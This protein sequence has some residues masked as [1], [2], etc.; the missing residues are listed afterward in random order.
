VDDANAGLSHLLVLAAIGGFACLTR[1]AG[2]PLVL[3]GAVHAFAFRGW[4]GAGWFSLAAALIVAPWLIWLYLRAQQPADSLFAYYMAYD[5]AGAPAGD[6]SAWLSSRF[7]IVVGNLR[8]LFD[9]FDLFYLT[10]LLPGSGILFGG[11][12]LL[13]LI[14]FARR[15]DPF[16][17]SLVV[18]SLA[19][20][21]IFGAAHRTF[22][23][24]RP[25]YDADL[26]PCQAWRFFGAAVVGKIGVVPISDRVAAQRSVAVGLSSHR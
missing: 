9:L 10:P 7:S 2:L 19:L 21:L 26:A 12:S 8:Y 15:Y 11:V 5:L 20:L 22:L 17:W 6:L 1:S 14:A 4:R 16:M 25:E 13:G 18:F 23:V 3:A 24:S